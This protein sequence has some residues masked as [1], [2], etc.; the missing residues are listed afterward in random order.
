MEEI[1]DCLICGSNSLEDHQSVKDHFGTQEV[2]QLQGCRQCQTLFT[3]PRPE[4]N[5]I[6]KYYKSG[7]YIS[8]GDKINTLFNRLYNLIQSQNLKYKQRI[9]EKYSFK[10]KLL[11]YGCGVGS[12]LQ[13]MSQKGWE[14]TGVE[15]DEQARKISTSR[16]LPV[17]ELN[18]IED[19]FNCISL[20]HVLEHVHSLNET[21][22]QL[23]TLLD[24]NG[25][26]ILALPNY[27]SYDA[28]H[29]EQFWAGYDVPRHLYHF[30][31]KSITHLAKKFG[32]N[33]VA[34][35]PLYFDSYYVSLLSEKYK[36]SKFPIVPAAVQGFI[37]NQKAKR[38]KEYSSLIYILS[39]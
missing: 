15:P 32:L 4:E 6:I 26:L 31:Q 19:C 37:S 8:H 22:E 30:S 17:K 23:C 13:H 36:G 5:K 3:N 14:V 34:T 2:F 20:F 33:I 1:R 9:V 28:Q 16:D 25:I 12:F 29:Y 35:H 39:K 11:D 24:R 21:L 27:K 7:S 10:G 38:N 18:Q